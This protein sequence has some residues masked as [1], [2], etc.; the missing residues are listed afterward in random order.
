MP[1]GWSPTGEMA[2]GGHAVA[3]SVVTVW[4]DASG[5]LALSPL[6]HADLV[7]RVIGAAVLTPVV[8]ALVLCMAGWAASRA[9]DRHRLARWERDP[10]R[11]RARIAGPSAS[12]LGQESLLTGWPVKRLWVL[13]LEASFIIAAIDAAPGNRVILIGLLIVGPCCVQLT[14]CGCRQRSA[15]CG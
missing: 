4:I 13:G 11:A 14:G 6:T 10:E 5:R 15:D 8:L 3:G 1:D 9:L 2:S 7:A 12:R